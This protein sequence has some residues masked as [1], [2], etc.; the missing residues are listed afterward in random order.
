LI[1]AAAPTVDPIAQYV[2]PA[3]IGILSGL[4]AAVIGAMAVLWNGARQREH[5]RVLD[6]QHLA[7][8]RLGVRREIGGRLRD[9]AEQVAWIR[10]IGWG[11][12]AALQAT[13]DRV[14]EIMRSD[15]GPASL[16][17]DEVAQTFYQMLDTARINL[18]F[19]GFIEAESRTAAERKAPDFSDQYER[20]GIMA[21][22]AISGTREALLKTL[23]QL[24][25]EVGA[26]T[27][28]AAEGPFDERMKAYSAKQSL[29]QGAIIWELQ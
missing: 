15:A 5:E 16:P 17:S 3:V 8:S 2:V 11:D 24:G 29:Q 13:F 18:R 10:K 28:R 26:E 27:L 9:F 7:D 21:S 25:D 4:L 19:L 6:R 22:N 1:A 14:N 12:N 23:E 20:F